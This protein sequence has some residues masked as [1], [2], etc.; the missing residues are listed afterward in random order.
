MINM[1]IRIFDDPPFL[2]G[3][4]TSRFYQAAVIVLFLL[5]RCLCSHFLFSFIIKCDF[6][7]RRFL[8][9][10]RAHKIR[11]FIHEM[12]EKKEEMSEVVTL[13]H[14]WNSLSH[15]VMQCYNY[16]YIHL[17]V[18]IAQLYPHFTYKYR[19]RDK[20]SYTHTHKHTSTPTHNIN[21]KIYY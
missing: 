3:R 19:A 15:W 5:C 12:C 13:F 14:I 7:V 4:P 16:I 1:Y 8:I 11:R 18:N 9:S 21:I 17:V 6:L 20:S 2:S 10:Y